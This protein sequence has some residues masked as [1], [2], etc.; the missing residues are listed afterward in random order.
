MQIWTSDGAT[1]IATLLCSVLSNRL[2]GYWLNTE[3]VTSQHTNWTSGLPGKGWKWKLF[4][5][6][7]KI[8]FWSTSEFQPSSRPS[9]FVTR[10]ILPPSTR[11]RM[12]RLL[13]L[14]AILGS[15]TAI[16]FFETPVSQSIHI[17]REG[18]KSQSLWG[19]PKK[20][21]IKFSHVKKLSS[22][23]YKKTFFCTFAYLVIP[24][25]MGFFSQCYASF[26][27]YLKSPDQHLWCRLRL[28]GN[29]Q[30]RWRQLPNYDHVHI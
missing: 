10:F 9:T 21:I 1:R 11:S 23:S 3:S 27:I 15:T 24:F 18:A 8:Y 14:F 25:N 30:P 22:F 7:A 19:S 26:D 29:P 6:Q 5:S 4:R 2:I 17:L 12:A 20:T 28:P 16:F 13:L